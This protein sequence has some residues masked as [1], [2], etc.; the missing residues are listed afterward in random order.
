VILS[1]FTFIVP[2]LL[3]IDR[4]QSKILS[5]IKHFL[6]VLVV[7]LFTF[8]DMLHLIFLKSPDI[9]CD[10]PDASDPAIDFCS[11]SNRDSYMR[12]YALLL[13]DFEFNDYRQAPTVVIVWALFTI[14]GVIIMLNVLIAVI[15]DSYSTSQGE[16]A[17]L[18]RQARAE[19]VSGRS[20]LEGFVKNASDSLKNETKQEDNLVIRGVSS[21]WKCIFSAFRHVARITLVVSFIVTSLWSSLFVIA[22]IWTYEP[23]DDSL[24]LMLGFVCICVSMS[25]GLIVMVLVSVLFLLEKCLGKTNCLYQFLSSILAWI[26]GITA[27]Y[28]FGIRVEETTQ[29]SGVANIELEGADANEEDALFA[30]LDRIEQAMQEAKTRTLNTLATQKDRIGELVSPPSSPDKVAG[31]KSS[32]RAPRESSVYFDPSLGLSNDFASASSSHPRSDNFSASTDR[33][34]G[35]LPPVHFSL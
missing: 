22:A 31:L 11:T 4:L 21:T 19:Y 16:S 30:K 14:F 26:V 32:M 29:S 35:S 10:D 3:L 23:G 18:F 9:D 1:T 6:V 28:L 33:S 24:L 2:H 15:C 7:I 12:M 25:T 17:R 34:A 27:S 20:A 8:G 5:D 13:G